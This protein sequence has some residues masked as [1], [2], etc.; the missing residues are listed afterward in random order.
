MFEVNKLPLETTYVERFDK[1]YADFGLKKTYDQRLQSSIKRIGFVTIITS[2]SKTGKTTLIRNNIE[3]G[4]I[5]E[6]SP[7]EVN[8]NYY[9]TIAEKINVLKTKKAT[10][11]INIS[12]FTKLVESDRYSNLK[13]EVIKAVKEQELIILFDDFHDIN[14]ELQFKLAFELK[15]LIESVKVVITTHP[16]LKHQLTTYNPDLNGRIDLIEIAKWSDAEIKQ[17]FQKGFESVN[18]KVDD[19]IID[20]CVTNSLNSPLIAQELGFNLV[21]NFSVTEITREA[22]RK[23]LILTCG[24]F[25]HA[26]IV[27]RI[28]DGSKGAVTIY[29]LKTGGTCQITKLLLICMGIDPLKMEHDAQSFLEKAQSLLTDPNQVNNDKIVRG[30]NKLV[31]QIDNERVINLIDGKVYTYDVTFLLYLKTILKF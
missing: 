1:Y 21:D 8:E 7:N 27:D 24:T 25:N 29:H 26:L 4:K 17:I 19:S 30:M 14:D 3:S 31:T 20:Y 9:Q 2:N 13:S 23:S 11:K 18:Y 22:V 15:N 6:L 16:H 10:E 5:I 12:L 28:K